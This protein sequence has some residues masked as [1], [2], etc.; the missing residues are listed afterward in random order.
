MFDRFTTMLATETPEWVYAEA[1]VTGLS[2]SRNRGPNDHMTIDI[3]I[4]GL[5]ENYCEIDLNDETDKPVDNTAR[6]IGCLLSGLDMVDHRRVSRK[7]AEEVQKIFTQLL[8]RNNV[9]IE[10]RTG[11]A[12]TIA[13]IINDFGPCQAAEDLCTVMDMHTNKTD[14][15]TLK[16]SLNRTE[17]QGGGL[18]DCLELQCGDKKVMGVLRANNLIDLYYQ[19]MDAE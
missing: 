15:D 14:V 1:R 18:T 13:N 9:L 2:P 11:L 5:G 8:P 7:D 19:L 3:S 4:P 6:R 17:V 16:I 10:D 12:C